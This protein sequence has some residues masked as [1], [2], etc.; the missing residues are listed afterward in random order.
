MSNKTIEFHYG[1]LAAPLEEQANQQGYTLGKYGET[2]SKL[3]MGLNIN[4]I[5]GILT[6]SAYDTAL[7]KL[8]KQVIAKCRPLQEKGV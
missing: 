6:E 2:V 3:Q 4:Y 8:H 1:A 7:K 5:H